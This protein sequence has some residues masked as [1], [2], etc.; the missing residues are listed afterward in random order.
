MSKI[1]EFRNKYHI[2]IHYNSTV[3][4]TV[5]EGFSYGLGGIIAKSN[6][7]KSFFKVF[8]ER[9]FDAPEYHACLSEIKSACSPEIISVVEGILGQK[10]LYEKLPTW[11]TQSNV[12]T[13]QYKEKDFLKDLCCHV[14]G[15]V[16]D[17][18]TD[19]KKVADTP[20]LNVAVN[21]SFA[22]L[23]APLLHVLYKGGTPE[24]LTP[25]HLAIIYSGVAGIYINKSLQDRYNAK[26]RVT[27]GDLS[28]PLE[29]EREQTQQ[30]TKAQEAELNRRKRQEDNK[31][32][33]K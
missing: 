12:I 17:M 15:I 25:M 4:S 16:E 5:E 31:G 29:E 3:F 18:L 22:A 10:M 32:V 28:H 30:Q 21:A 27:E 20:Y 33:C 1:E 24:S 23:I 19:V 6:L 2:S 7:Q 14:D 8:R 26:V 13:D 11:I 9:N